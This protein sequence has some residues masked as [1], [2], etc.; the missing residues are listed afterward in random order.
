MTIRREHVPGLV[1]L[2]VWL[3]V[4]TIY[5]ITL[6]PTVPF[7]D[8]GEFIACSYILGIPHPPGTPFYVLI[9]RVFTLV[10]WAT[11]AQ[12]INAMSA[13]PS[14]VTI[15]FTYLCGFKLIRIA[16]G[17]ERPA[18][19][20]WIAHVGAVTGALLMAFSDNFWENSIEAE[21]YSFMSLAQIIVLW[22]GLRWWERHEDRPTAAPL[23][24]A[25]YILWLS[26][27]LHLGVGIMGFPL[28]LLV[29]LV[30]RRASVV[31]LMPFMTVMLV[32]MGMERMV[33]A[34]L[35]L[36]MFSFFVW[37]MQGKLKGWVLALAAVGGAIGVYI[38]FS[39]VNFS[40]PTALIALASIV[41]PLVLLARRSQEGKILAL[42]VALMVIGYSTHAYLPIRARLH[43][44]INEGDP[45]TWANF[46]DLLERKQ[47]GQM[48]MFVRRAPWSVQLNKEFW[49]YFV[50]QWPLFQTTRLWG[51]LLP[52]LL[53]VVGCW[54]Q[55]R[56]DKKSWL[57]IGSFFMLS[58]GGLI[59]FLNFSDH[60]V[61]DR[62][63]FFQSGYHA[64]AL[65]IGMGIAWVIEWVRESFAA[66][67][68]TRR[69]ATIATAVLLAAQ[70]PLLIGNLWYTHDRRGNYVARDY[71]YNMLAP[72]KPH[73]FIFTN[74][75]NDTFPLWYIQQVEGFRKDVRIA[76]LS[77]L[78]TDW[79]IRQLRDEEP[80]VPITLDDPTINL[81]GAGAV[82]TPDG[83]VIQT[84]EFM[85]HHLL[86]TAKQGA[87]GWSMQPYFA[88]TVPEHYGY[89]KYFTLEALVDRVN[90]DT[91]EGTLDVPAMHH[92]LYEVFKYRG[93]F[94]PDGSQDKSVY[95]DDNAITLSR[96]YAAAH[97]QLAL[98]YHHHDQLPAAIAEMER[99][100]RMF[101]DFTEVLV[102]LGSFY[103]E[104]KDTAKAVD[105]FRRLSTHDDPS[106][107]EAHYYY[108]VTLVSQ[109]QIEPA[110]R[111]FDTAIRLD[112]DYPNPVYAAYYALLDHGQRQRAEGYLERWADTHPQEAAQTRQMLGD[113]GGPATPDTGASFMPR[114]PLPSLP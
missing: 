69:W 102:P 95:K 56:R 65:W 76:N 64:Y 11:V 57:Y 62:D 31:Y 92:N 50:R 18:S 5:M 33:G 77:L 26:V 14:A 44:A 96:N 74:G 110:V 83:N 9:G 53:G 89:D 113:K 43:P 15:L 112:P 23:L 58:T 94:K 7:W 104:A 47:Y 46:R 71:A 51:T 61:R 21:V 73:S 111:E 108:G 35:G 84:N 60:E 88:V 20:D 3:L 40:L 114:S 78:N 34:V 6:A 68:A 4:A 38:G 55:F 82:R 100:E 48:N 59:V 103:M 41:V 97:I 99:V 81:L 10:P 17:K 13:L 52:L 98:Y 87:N 28:I 8:A 80:K 67:T 37:T 90:R 72:L 32:T 85:V 12:R 93:L 75:D 54:W 27:G 70:T 109:R 25:I 106:N 42:A 22:L 107:P 79:Y 1:A 39:D 24:L 63:Y 36:S 2:G 105:L 30:D 86:E 16:Q 66:G 101:P 91:T 29:W 19:D 49:R 45:S